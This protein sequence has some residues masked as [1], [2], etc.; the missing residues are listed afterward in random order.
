LQLANVQALP[1]R[2]ERSPVSWVLAK[3]QIPRRCRSSE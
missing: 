3:Q 2:G 1:S